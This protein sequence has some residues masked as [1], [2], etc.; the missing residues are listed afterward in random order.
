MAILTTQKIVNAG[1]APNFALDTLGTTNTAEVGNGKNNFLVVKNGSGSSVTLT[2]VVVGNTS[3]GQPEPDP[4]FTVAAAGEVWVPL[5][6][7]YADA[8]G[9][10]VGRCTV[11]LS[12]ATSVTGAVVQM[13]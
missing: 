12:A 6:K 3:Y 5:R 4:T 9:A 8:S 1:T 2:V 13:G 10:G 11:T 7:E